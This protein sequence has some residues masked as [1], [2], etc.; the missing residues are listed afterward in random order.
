VSEVQRLDYLGRRNAQR[1][2]TLAGRLRRSAKD[3]GID[4]SLRPRRLEPLGF[5]HSF[6]LYGEHSNITQGSQE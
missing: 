4:P 3:A 1:K 2:H 5:I 6:D